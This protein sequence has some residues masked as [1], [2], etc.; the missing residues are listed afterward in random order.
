[1]SQ[2]F[3]DSDWCQT[4]FAHCYLE[5][6]KDPA[7]KIFMI[8]MQPAECLENLSGYKQSFMESR[9]HLSKYDPQLFQKIVSYLHWVKMPKG[10][11][12]REPPTY[13]A[14][15]ALL[16]KQDE[17]DD[18]TDSEIEIEYVPSDPFLCVHNEDDEDKNY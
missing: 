6:M 7:F 1:M 3:I 11:K 10:E 4:E 12:S 9:T 14:D 8:M 2:A 17:E 15:T 5:N 18:L 16:R 13:D